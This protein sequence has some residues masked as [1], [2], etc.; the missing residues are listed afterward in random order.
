[1]VDLATLPLP[2]ARMKAGRWQR[3]FSFLLLYCIYIP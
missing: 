3:A 2:E 1:M